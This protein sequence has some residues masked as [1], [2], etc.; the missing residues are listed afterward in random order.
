MSIPEWRNAY[1]IVGHQ[2]VPEN[3]HGDPGDLKIARL[4]RFAL[5]TAGQQ[6]VPVQGQL[7]VAAPEPASPNRVQKARA[8]LRDARVD[9]HGKKKQ[10]IKRAL[11]ALRIT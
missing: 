7:P 1:G 2:H 5:D 10:R 11:K 4:L 3:V 9:S 8:L 6:E